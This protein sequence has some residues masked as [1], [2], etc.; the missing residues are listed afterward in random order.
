MNIKRTVSLLVTLLMAV[1]LVS[2][3]ND[4]P[5][6]ITPDA[7]AEKTTQQIAEEIINN[8][9]LQSTVN[10]DT[11][12]ATVTSAD[13]TDASDLS[14]TAV[15][16]KNPSEMSEAE[17][18][19]AYKNAAV[20]SATGVMSQHSVEI[21]KIIIN[22]EEL[23][24]GFDFIKKIINKFISNNTEDSKGITGG[25]TK[26]TENDAASA[27]AYS[28]GNNTAIEMVMKNQTDGAKT[29]I[30]SGSVGHAID[31]VGDISVVTNELTELGL[32]IEIPSESVT[33]HYTN[34]TV[35]VLIDGNG[36]IVKGTWSYTVEIRLNNYKVF[37]TNV[38]SSSIIMNNVITVNGGF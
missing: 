11:S 38:E 34:P 33:I 5:Q 6:N 14:T 16:V 8:D 21:T 31:V 9:I 28:A 2:C 15:S 23:G 24:S 37:G 25:Y 12:T 29:D 22:G 20:K 17:I 3:K 19:E 26:L 30:H 10:S 35:K 7:S 27:K 18:I 36:K 13:T 32:P 1:S 4:N